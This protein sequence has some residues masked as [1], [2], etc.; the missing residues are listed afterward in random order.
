MTFDD[1]SWWWWRWAPKVFEKM[2]EFLPYAV[3]LVVGFVTYKIPILS[4]ILYSSVRKFSTEQL[5]RLLLRTKVIFCVSFIGRKWGLKPHVSIGFMWQPR[6]WLFAQQQPPQYH[7]IIS[8]ECGE[9]RG[10]G[11]SGKLLALR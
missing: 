11:E 6:G 3:E 5:W 1:G 4:L 7:M 10:K 8:L 9:A 2:K